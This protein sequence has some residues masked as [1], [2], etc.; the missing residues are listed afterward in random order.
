M[1]FS[2]RKWG[3]SLGRYDEQRVEL[4]QTS[5][6]AKT[7][8][9]IYDFILQQQRDGRAIETIRTR[10]QALKQVAK[11]TNLYEPEKVKEWLATSTWSN[12]TK[13]KFVDS[14][15]AFLNFI[16][17]TWKPPHY[18]IAKKLPFIPTEEEIDLLIASCGTITATVLQT[19]KET[20][21][22]IG[23][24]TRL[25]AIDL[26]T[27]RK[28]LSITP[29]KNSN[30]RILP[31][32]DKLLG[33][34]KNLPKDPRAHYKTMFQPDKHALRQYLDNQR[35][36]LAER[37]DNPRIRKISFHTLRHWKG[38]M[39]YH[40]THDLRH[41]QKILGHKSI[42]TT[43]IYEN[44]ESALWLQS[45]DGFTCKIAD[46]IEEATKLIEIGFEYVTDMDGKKLFRKRK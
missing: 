29:E 14:Y 38:T 15:T 12:T 43:T 1:T 2:G 17:K 9:L 25:T 6:D 5:L 39:E 3:R 19:L 33:M 40:Q 20:G 27:E 11:L 28:T 18:T 13:T 32:S 23:E 30:P 26:D 21:I 41:V 37:L 46:T 35:N 42:N 24:L 22:R 31:I 7:N 44:T 10:I 8:Q 34:L 36:K 4:Q 45:N 16:G